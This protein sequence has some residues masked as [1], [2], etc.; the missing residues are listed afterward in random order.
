[1]QFGIR[2]RTSLVTFLLVG[3]AAVQRAGADEGMWLLN[4]LPLKELKQR[5]DFTP[6]DAWVRHVMRSCVRMGSGGSGSLV[7]RDGLV[8]TNHHIAS[9]H[10][11]NI[12][13]PGHDYLAD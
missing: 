11:V 2:L 3:V 9:H 7:S 5:H 10:L 4:Q 6:N 12:S 8:I 13:S 1:M